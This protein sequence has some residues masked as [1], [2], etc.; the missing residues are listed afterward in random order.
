MLKK[1]K[2]IEVLTLLLFA[3]VFLF[4]YNFSK[5]DSL[6][7]DIDGDGYIIWHKDDD[8]SINSEVYIDPG[9]TLVIEKGSKVKLG[10]Y[11]Y[12]SVNGGRIVANGTN[13]EPIE[14]TSV[15]PD[16]S[17]LME[18]VYEKRDGI[19]EAEPSFLRYVQFSSG[20]YEESQCIDCSAFLQYILPRAN[21]FSGGTPALYFRGGK[22]H[23]ENC[24]FNDNKYADIGVEY[25]KNS[26]NSD[27]Y[28]L[29]II[30]SNF[31]G[32]SESVAIKSDITCEDAGIS[33]M[34]K[35]LL[36]NNWYGSYQGPTE[37][38]DSS[39]KGKQISG[40]YMLDGFRNNDLIS[41]PTVVIP[42][43]MG[44]FEVGGNLVLDPI[45]KTY[46]N[47]VNSLD[48][49]GYQENVNLFEFP[50]EW[51]NS[52]V[53]TADLLKQKIQEIKS[54]TKVSKVDLVAHSMGGLL[55]RQYIEGDDYQ[56]D[57]DQ[58][59]TLGAPHRGSPK[60]YL[61][62][63]AAEGFNDV[64]D[65]LGKKLFEMEA[66]HNGYDELKEY[67]QE[68][69]VSVGELLP[70]DDYLKENGEIRD[71]PNGYPRNYFLENLNNQDNLD[72][73]KEVDFTNI[74][75][76]NKDTISKFRVVES[77]V[78]GKWEHGM[79]ENYYNPRTDR[80][81]EYGEGDETVTVESSTGINSDKTID[82]LDATHTQLP[83]R[84]Q[85][86]ILAE[87]SNKAENEC[88]YINDVSEIASILTFGVFSPVDIQIVAPNGKRVGKDFESGEIINE[89]EGA[90][91]SGFDS[92]NEFLTIPNPVDGKYKIF[93]Q[94]TGDGNYKIEVAKIT[95][96][97]ATGIASE[98]T[99]TI[100]GAAFF[101]QEKEEE[102]RVE[103]SEVS[104][105]NQDTIPPVISI[106]SPEEN[107]NYLNNQT[108][109][110]SYNVSDDVSRNIK[111]EVF[112]DGDIFTDQN[113]NL[114]FQNLGEHTLKITATDEAGNKSEKEVKFK[115]ETDIQSIIDNVNIYSS[116]G[117]IKNM[118]K[119]IL[120][121]R[122]NLIREIDGMIES[123]ERN[124]FL[125]SRLKEFLVKALKDQI[126]WNIDWL[127]SYVQQ[128]SRVGVY[129]G[130]NPKV[131][132]LLVESF[133]F[134]KYK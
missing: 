65:K 127:I 92:N 68:K 57:V 44:S 112:L 29:E 8:L 128:R 110:I 111:T 27:G 80:G 19:P 78:E 101:G 52:N 122:L 90:Y 5:A 131:G 35:V 102:V 43:I 69:I 22:L 85:C 7:E 18:F 24:S 99:A 132:W 20:G 119:T 51:R 61:K 104:V 13:D 133:N 67:I 70:D 9:M 93:T 63:E 25:W 12:I 30:N 113:V 45:L 88:N 118:D 109:R 55:A 15:Y 62:W 120:T 38:D 77:T 126:N 4:S 40:V 16:S 74:I 86:K 82:D 72:N 84:A 3:S 129:N 28:S 32:D 121:Y 94:G 83:S 81:I 48:Q 37:E 115:I 103:G 73:L 123:I 75:G 116:Q 107:K 14:I 105:G 125:S 2:L 34:K 89:I 1:K 50:Y 49:N 100:E 124:I 130:I 47:L 17:A 95:E 117:L 46:S 54:Q 21:A 33:C 59:I 66:K 41:D 108:I 71:Y 98:S 39:E 42:G 76:K 53:I 96:D 36:K 31:L 114:S 134:V 97:S 87:L 64:L 26:E 23:I 106:L 11:A 6:Y 10:Q 91:Y 60:S 79:P 58:L 56:N